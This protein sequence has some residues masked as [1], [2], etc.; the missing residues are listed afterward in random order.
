G[1]HGDLAVARYGLDGKLD[2]TFSGDG[3]L[4]IGKPG[5]VVSEDA[6]GVDS[7]GRIKILSGDLIALKSDGTPDSSFAPKGRLTH[8]QLAVRTGLT[9]SIDALAVTSTGVTILGGSFQTDLQLF[10]SDTSALNSKGQTVNA[11]FHDG[12]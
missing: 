6:L 8:A 5:P 11:G 2:T 1:S 7:A 10:T 3:K 9:G 4:L 12:T